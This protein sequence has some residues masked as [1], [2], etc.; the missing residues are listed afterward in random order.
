ML[1]IPQTHGKSNSFLLLT[2]DNDGT[3]TVNE[4][5]VE[6]VKKFLFRVQSPTGNFI[7]LFCLKTIYTQYSCT[8]CALKST[9]A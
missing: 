8:Q 2:A 1:F 7:S 3:L 4:N 5:L 6:A 9:D